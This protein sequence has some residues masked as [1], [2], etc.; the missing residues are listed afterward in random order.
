MRSP[1]KPT[2]PGR[3]VTPQQDHD[4]IYFSLHNLM[5]LLL[6]YETHVV[7]GEERR[8]QKGVGA[9]GGAWH[10]YPGLSCPFLGRV[11]APSLLSSFFFCSRLQLVGG[12]AQ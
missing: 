2:R 1:Q 11:Q 9:Y 7:F 8:E 10:Q 6:L 3:R 5:L 4:F 12:G